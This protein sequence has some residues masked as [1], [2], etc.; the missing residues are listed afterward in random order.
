MHIAVCDDNIADRKQLE[1]LLKRESDK[2]I[3]DKRLDTSN[4][5]YT[6]SFGNSEVL[7]KNPMQYDLF[8]IDMTEEEP[9]GFAFA[10]QLTKAGVQAPIVLCSSKIDYLSKINGLSARTEQFMH[11]HKPI[12]TKELSDVIDR[13]LVL[14]EN[15]IPTIEL[16]SETDTFY[17]KEDD[18]VYAVPN[19]TY[20]M[21]ALRNGTVVPLHTDMFNF[22]HQVSMFTHMVLINEKGLFNIIDMESYSL[23]KVTLKNGVQLK[24]TPFAAKYIKSALH[25]YHAETL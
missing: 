23:F 14:C 22:Y 25:M 17:V 8:F 16:R 18:I 24:S 19:G 15:R 21:V 13:A 11:L 4:L 9:D 10:L 7:S 12:L 5:L 20:V 6:D 1:R 2:R 3:K